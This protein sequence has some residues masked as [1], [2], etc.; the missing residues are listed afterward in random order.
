MSDNQMRIHEAWHPDGNCPCWE[1]Q[2]LT[3]PTGKYAGPNPKPYWRNMT[4]EPFG[5]PKAA[6]DYLFGGLNTQQED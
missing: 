3:M 1:A 4:K 6:W 5:N 2:E